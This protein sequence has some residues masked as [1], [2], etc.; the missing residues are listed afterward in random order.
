MSDHPD[1]A[2]KPRRKHR[3]L[4]GWLAISIV[5]LS[6]VAL[7]LLYLFNNRP[8]H[9]DFPKTALPIPNGYDDFA[10]AGAIAE[11]N[12]L[13]EP[14]HLAFRQSFTVTEAQ[15]RAHEVALAPAI[16]L[17]RQGLTKP[18]VCPPGLKVGTPQ[19]KGV[20]G[21]RNLCWSLSSIG[22]HR[23][24]HGK[25]DKA[26]DLWLDGLMMCARF[27]R[28]SGMLAEESIRSC[29]LILMGDI[30]GYAA[31]MSPDQIRRVWTRLKTIYGE[32]E[33]FGQ[34]YRA[35]AWEVTKN[36]V[37][38]LKDP[39]YLGS[40]SGIMSKMETDLRLAS[41]I[42]HSP[43]DLTWRDR[44]R[45]VG[46]VMANKQRLVDE[47]RA[48]YLEFASALDSEPYVMPKIPP[49]TNVMFDD[50]KIG[51]GL[52][53]YSEAIYQVINTDMAV[54]AYRVDHGNYPSSLSQLAPG[55]LKGVPGDPFADGKPL[56]YVVLTG[57]T[58]FRL[59]SVWQNKVDDGG[60]QQATGGGPGDYVAG[61]S[62]RF[63]KR[64]F[65]PS[66]YARASK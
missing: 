45:A 61:W 7:F 17:M 22:V 32:R 16:V 51:Y 66:P 36:A 15:H 13:L 19:W 50:P 21:V 59:Y 18:C 44:V 56:R 35:E 34:I 26:L 62:A 55:Y 57:G 46:F 9:V 52:L 48:Y 38:G 41:P 37:D 23:A 5:P 10:A 8:P 27:P 1:V 63:V 11:A 54:R 14:G 60:Q 29:A 39:A 30:D 43:P 65:E 25:L 53:Q 49:P 3:L 2:A 42:P 40:W 58:D 4:R 31:E 6:V 12:S 20:S 47:N 24:M 28:S 33:S 64:R